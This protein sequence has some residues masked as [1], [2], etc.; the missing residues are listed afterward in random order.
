VG[1]YKSGSVEGWAS[2]GGMAQVAEKVLKA[3]ERKGRKTV[4]LDRPPGTRITARDVGLAAQAGDAVAL[5]ILRSCG[6]RLGQAMAILVD[7]VN[8]ECIVVGGMAM[9]L[10]ELILG[11]ARKTLE[12]EALPQAFAVCRVVPAQLGERIGD[13]AALCI[14]MDA[15]SGA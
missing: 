13:V 1:Y 7:V 4:L 11:P 5:S 3:A 10:G 2:G 9:R 14:A 15:G 8:P 12:K 6:R